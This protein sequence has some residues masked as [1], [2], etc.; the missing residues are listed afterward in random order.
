MEATGLSMPV[1]V[2]TVKVIIYILHEF[3]PLCK[4]DVMRITANR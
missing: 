2:S 3:F 4:Y 1:N